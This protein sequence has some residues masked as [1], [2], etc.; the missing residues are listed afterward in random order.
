MNKKHNKLEL[1]TIELETLDKV[2][3]GMG[4]APMMMMIS[5]ALKSDSGGGS[6]SGIG[7]SGSRVKRQPEPSKAAS[8]MGGMPGAASSPAGG[9]PMPGAQ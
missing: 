7:R 6:R 2:A 3:G 8:M 9:M 5:S 1:E 4:S